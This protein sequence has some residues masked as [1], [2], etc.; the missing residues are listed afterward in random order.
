[1]IPIFSQS[2]TPEYLPEIRFIAGVESIPDLDS[3]RKLKSRGGLES[4]PFYRRFEAF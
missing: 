2:S 1:M 3:E 4:A